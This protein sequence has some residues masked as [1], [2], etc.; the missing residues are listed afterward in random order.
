MRKSNSRIHAS[1]W[2]IADASVLY[3]CSTCAR[4]NHCKHSKGSGSSDT[5]VHSKASKERIGAVNFVWS[6]RWVH[7]Q[8]QSLHCLPSEAPSCCILCGIQY[9]RSRRL[10]LDSLHLWC[11]S[12][13]GNPKFEIPFDNR[14]KTHENAIHEQ[15]SN[16]WDLYNCL[17]TTRNLYSRVK[18]PENKGFTQHYCRLLHLLTKYAI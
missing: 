3:L 8:T 14:I 1:K 10:L 15:F 16:V 2:E 6:R 7:R 17:S 12:S 9:M 11:R 4:E 18:F 5:Y 13:E